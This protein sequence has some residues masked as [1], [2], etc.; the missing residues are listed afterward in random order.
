MRERGKGVVGLLYLAAA[1]GLAACAGTPTT[2]TEAVPGARDQDAPQNLAAGMV[3]IFRD[4]IS[5][6]DADRCPSRPSCA[7]YGVQAFNKH[8]FLLG[9]LMTV[10]RLIHE[11]SEEAAV[12]PLVFEH[13]RFQ[14]YDPVENNDF[15]WADRRGHAPD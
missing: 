8:G 1:L 13:D 5:A 9:W 6:V 15:W 10:D 3:S 7:Q 4:H 11:G 12:S 14:I 2:R